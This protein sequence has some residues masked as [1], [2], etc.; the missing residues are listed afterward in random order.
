MFEEKLIETK[1]IHNGM[2]L[3]FTQDLIQLSDGTTGIRE[4]VS[5]NDGCAVVAIDSSKN[6][7]LVQ[8]FRYAHQTTLLELPAGAIEQNETPMDAAKRELYEET[9]FKSKEWQDL[10]VILPLTYATQKTYMFLAKNAYQAGEPNPDAGEILKTQIIPFDEI[11]NMLLKN[12]IK[13][14]KTIIGILKT[15]IIKQIKTN[16]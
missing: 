15:V 14:S 6:V 12:E 1:K 8:Q 11:L 9:G 5:T 16:L 2:F 3:T 4:F 13:D 7:V 10:G